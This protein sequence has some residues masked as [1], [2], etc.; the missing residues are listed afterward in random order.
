[1]YLNSDDSYRLYWT[2]LSDGW[3]DIGLEVQTLGWIGFGI[4]P[5]GM[6]PNSDIVMG[7]VDDY[8][9]TVMLQNRYTLDERQTPTEMI[10]QTNIELVDGYQANGT[11]FLRFHRLI[12]P[13]SAHSIAIAS[14]AATHVIFASNPE[15]PVNNTPSYHGYGDPHRG[16]V[17][18]TLVENGETNEVD[19]NGGGGDDDDPSR[20]SKY[21]D[22]GS[23]YIYAGIGFFVLFLILCTI[24]IACKCCRRQKETHQM[25]PS[26]GASYYVSVGDDQNT[27]ELTSFDNRVIQKW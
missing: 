21:L 10:D 23:W 22:W 16:T 15:L 19:C 12:H 3:I 27:N 18:L 24:F 4:S 1:M 8:N 5:D 2:V 6:M 11:T 26:S 25:P 17:S 13:C 7:W 9:M 20:I 14:G